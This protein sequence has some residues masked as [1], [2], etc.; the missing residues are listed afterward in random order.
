MGWCA[1]IDRI[2]KKIQVLGFAA[3]SKMS[4][5]MKQQTTGRHKHFKKEFAIATLADL[6]AVFDP[7]L[8]QVCEGLQ[9]LDSNETERLIKV[10]FQYRNHSAH[11]GKAPIED[12]HLLAFFTDINRIILTNP[13]FELT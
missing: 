6:Q 11:P 7:D 4:T 9:L 8:I 12:P 10:D 3:F 1:A 13:K 2:Q 5:Q